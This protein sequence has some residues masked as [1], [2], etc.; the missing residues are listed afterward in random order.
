MDAPP[1]VGG[2]T[3]GRWQSVEFVDNGGVDGP[4]SVSWRIRSGKG[5]EH[6]ADGRME[7]F[8][9]DS[10]GAVGRVH[11]ADDFLADGTEVFS[12]CPSPSRVAGSVEVAAADSDEENLEVDVGPLDP[13]EIA[14]DALLLTV[15]VPM[16]PLRGLSLA[17]GFSHGLDAGCLRSADIS[18]E[19]VARG[20]WQR[21]QVLPVCGK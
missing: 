1:L 3:V 4:D 8:G 18:E 20:R 5:R 15:S 19:R 12:H 11:H 13:K 14:V 16:G 17:G 10:S 6:F 9:G 2:A 21:R 7:R